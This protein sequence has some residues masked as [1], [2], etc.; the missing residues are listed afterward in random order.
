VGLVPRKAEAN[1]QLGDH[2]LP[3]L[4]PHVAEGFRAAVQQHP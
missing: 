2:A 3:A 1:K 4:F